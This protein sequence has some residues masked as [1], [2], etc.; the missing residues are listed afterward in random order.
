MKPS[1]PL[2]LLRKRLLA[3]RERLFR[4]LQGVEAEFSGL[5]GL[6]PVEQAES[7]QREGSLAVLTDLDEREKRA[8]EEIE[9]ALAR[10]A[11]GTY[12]IC[13]ACGLPIPLARLYASPATPF[14]L[15]CQAE[16]EQSRRKERRP[17]RVA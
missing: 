15:L 2:G 4:L 17:L 1:A 9:V 12:G 11:A 16:R 6:R 8:L 7:A 10:I 13:E 5:A 14:C 3:E